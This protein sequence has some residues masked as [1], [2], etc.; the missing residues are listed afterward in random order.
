VHVLAVGRGDPAQLDGVGGGGEAA[1]QGL[2]LRDEAAADAAEAWSR[3]SMLGL[4]LVGAACPLPQ[5]LLSVAW[6]L[7]TFGFLTRQ[8]MISASSPIKRTIDRKQQILHHEQPTKMVRH[9]KKLIAGLGHSRS[10]LAP[11]ENIS[12][13]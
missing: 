6:T 4:D 9:R 5:C 13:I 12:A 3:V 1:R 7:S 2:E 8:R 11:D 10:A